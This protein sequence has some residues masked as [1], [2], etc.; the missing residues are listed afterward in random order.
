MRSMDPPR[1]EDAVDAPPK[2]R[3]FAALTP[4]QRAEIGRRGGKKAV[5]IGKH[6]AFTR[7]QAREAGRKGGLALQAKRR[8]ERG[9]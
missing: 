8:A 4:E 3:G 1:D 5:A 7:E 9:E 6:H 2:L